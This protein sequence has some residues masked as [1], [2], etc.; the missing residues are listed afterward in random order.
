[1][2]PPPRLVAGLL[3]AI[4]APLLSA[5]ER[6]SL[7]FREDWREIPAA[8]PVTPEHV[9]NPDLE[10]QLHGKGRAGIKKSHHDQPLDDPYYIWSGMCE[11]GNWAVSL[12]PRSGPFDLTGQAKVRW[13]T[14]QSGFRVLRLIVQ[15]AS[16]QWLIAADTTARW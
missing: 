9:A 4:A 14:K 8:L 13:R 3:L 1:M 7:L 11:T 5:Q 6:P 15:L 16:G 10:L 12:K 2:F